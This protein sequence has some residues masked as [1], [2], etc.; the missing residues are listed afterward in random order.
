MGGGGGNS[1]NGA[2]GFPGSAG[3]GSTGG[4]GSGGGFSLIGNT[5]FRFRFF[6]VGLCLSKDPTCRQQNE[7][8]FIDPAVAVTSETIEHRRLQHRKL[9]A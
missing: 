7:W 8:T 2:V 5:A 1:G 9:A 3:G 4:G 6:V